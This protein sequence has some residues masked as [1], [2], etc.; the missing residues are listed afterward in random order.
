[1]Q[2]KQYI[3]G[4]QIEALQGVSMSYPYM[5][6]GTTVKAAY[7]PSGRSYDIVCKDLYHV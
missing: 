7:S 1:M 3:N 6:W 2:N 5:G 4:L